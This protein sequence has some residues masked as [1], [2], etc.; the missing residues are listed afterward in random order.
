MPIYQLNANLV[1]ASKQK[2]LFPFAFAI[3]KGKKCQL[4]SLHLPAINAQVD[5]AQI[6]INS[7]S[8]RK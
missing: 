7:I 4:I 5:R 1:I 2:D 6:V 3:Q 8:S